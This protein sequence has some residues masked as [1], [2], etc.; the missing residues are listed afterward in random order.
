MLLLGRFPPVPS[1]VFLYVAIRIPRQQHFVHFL[2]NALE[3]L[4][5]VKVVF[6]ASLE[7]IGLDPSSQGLPSDLSTD[8]YC[9]K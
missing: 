8:L 7:E 6:G 5:Y 3:N 2:S 9:S 1:L 4:L